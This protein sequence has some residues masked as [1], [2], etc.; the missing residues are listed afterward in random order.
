MSDPFLGS[1]DFAERAHQLYNEG[2][3]EDAIVVL[4]DGLEVYP[5]AAELHVGLGYAQLAREEFVWARKSFDDALTLDPDHED[6]LVGLGE[7]LLRFGRHGDAL[8]C[9]ERVLVL[10]FRDDHDLMLQAGRA[11]FR[12][13]A[14][15]AARRYFQIAVKAHAESAEAAACLGYAEHRL[16]DEDGAIQWLRHAL[17]L[18]DQH[19]E[20]RIY[21]GNLL[22]DR[23]EFDAALYH[24]DRTE[25]RD[26][27]D[28][29]AI[30]RLI[31]LK[32]SIYRLPP[33]DPELTAWSTR[34]A[35]LEE[36]TDAIDTLLGAIEATQADGSI[37]D[38]LQLELFGTLLME[39]EGMRHRAGT[40][41]RVTTREGIAYAGTWE[42]IVLQMK[43]DDPVWAARSLAGFLAYKARRA[44]AETGVMISGTD[45]EAFVLGSAAAGLLRI[46][47]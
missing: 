43:Q 30:W 22:Y 11:L 14:T 15:A 8:A 4:R 29:L 17:E 25:P 1:E 39:L 13:G 18:D 42:E 40:A 21:L 12:E 24:F 16:G 46:V 7:A 3:Y 41:H 32:K 5:F 37:R 44:S 26:H 35:E 10:G 34:L 23:G 47:R 19:V 36:E 31:E 38:P 9:F 27:V 2:R 33:D 6:G 20:A 45:A 28:E